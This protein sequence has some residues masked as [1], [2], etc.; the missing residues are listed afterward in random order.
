M[1]DVRKTITGP[2][3]RERRRVLRT[4]LIFLLPLF[5]LVCPALHARQLSVL[6]APGVSVTFDAPLAGVARDVAQVYPLVRSEL[7][8]TLGRTVDFRPAVLLVADR[9]TFAQMAGSTLFAAYALPGKL[10]MVIDASRLSTEPSSLAPTL[11]H[12][13]CHL[14]L[15][16]SLREAPLPRWLDEGVCQWASGG[17]A[18]LVSGRRQSAL[19]WA[20]LTGTFLPLKSLEQGF[21][22]DEHSLAL[23]YEESRSLVE[24]IVAT[25][26]RS[27]ILNILEAVGSG[28]AV[29]DAVGT[30]LGIP[31]DALEQQWQE[32]QRTWTVILSSLVGNLYTLLFVCAALLTIAAYI[33]VRIRKRRLTDEEE[34]EEEGEDPSLP[35][36]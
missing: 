34:E 16:R 31:L 24:Y 1:I 35:E 11:K 21:P 8:T 32:S 18:E 7:E 25:Y 10:L 5:L 14:L 23:A 2:D 27:G 36:G 20:A 15:H 17:F 19:A 26:G 28:Y 12:E 22:D 33:R 4:G 30:G 13:L 6:E 29:N 9:R 3:R